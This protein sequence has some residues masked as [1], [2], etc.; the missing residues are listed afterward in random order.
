MGTGIVSGTMIYKEA[1]ANFDGSAQELREIV[2]DMGTGG[3]GG[4][5]RDAAQ[6]AL[7]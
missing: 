7:L 6:P 2:V 1:W 3:R 5:C 4:G